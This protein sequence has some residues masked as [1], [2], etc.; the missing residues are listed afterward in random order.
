MIR[1]FRRQLSTKSP[2]GSRTIVKRYNEPTLNTYLELAKPRLTTLVVLST[3]SSYA[4]SPFPATSLSTLMFLTLGTSLCSAS[5]NAF[6][7]WLEPPFDAQMTRTQNRP[8]VRGALPATNAFLFGSAAGFTGVTAL[9]WGVNPLCSFLGLSNII[10]YAGIYTPLKRLSVLNT[11]VGAVVGAIPPMMGWAAST[12]YPT[13]A[14][15]NLGGLFPALLLYAWQFPHFNSLSWY[16]RAEY[17]RAGYVMASVVNPA[18]NARVSLRYSLLT[19]PICYGMVHT[20]ICNEWFLIDSGIVNLYLVHRAW[21]FWKET[22]SE[23]DRDKK[24]KK[25]FFASLIYLP[26]V[27][28]L[29]MAHKQGLWDPLSS[30]DVR[31]LAVT[32]RGDDDVDTISDVGH[33]KMRQDNKSTSI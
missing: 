26:A 19:F 5:A 1:R 30:A 8:L 24:A 18:M 25:L 11:W 16:I 23:K 4:L 6:N 22:G 10:L 28:L 33:E 14:L 31:P 29:A 15:E 13:F 12:P 9:M 32:V 27:L 20:G 17:A 3:M 2:S 7:M 21:D